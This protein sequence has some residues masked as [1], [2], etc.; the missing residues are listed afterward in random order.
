V[1]F[2]PLTLCV[3]LQPQHSGFHFWELDGVL[4]HQSWHVQPSE[5]PRQ[6]SFLNASGTQ[7]HQAGKCWPSTVSAGPVPGGQDQPMNINLP[8]GGAT[9]RQ[10]HHFQGWLHR[11]DPAH[12]LNV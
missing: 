10:N 4:S 2:P 9:A 3:E 5:L 1:L 12:K 7:R 8:A 11:P 6:A